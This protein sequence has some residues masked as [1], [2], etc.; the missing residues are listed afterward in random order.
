MRK[1]APCGKHRYRVIVPQ[2]FSDTE[3]KT[4]MPKKLPEQTGI[5]RPGQSL[6]VPTAEPQRNVKGGKSAAGTAIQ[7]DYELPADMY[8]DDRVTRNPNRSAIIRNQPIQTAGD[9]TVRQ[10]NKRLVYH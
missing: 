10:G 2:V 7:T 3:R 4:P 6:L 5:W 9:F 1:Q 8:P